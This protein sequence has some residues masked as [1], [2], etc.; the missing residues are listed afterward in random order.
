MTECVSNHRAVIYDRGGINKLWE[1][2]D[3]SRVIWDRRRDA[4]S[5]ATI[6]L[7]GATCLAQNDT[8]KQIR[9]S[10]HELVIFRGQ[11]RVWEGPITRAHGM[12]TEFSIFAKDVLH[13]TNRTA[14]HYG[15]DNRHPNTTTVLSRAELV[16]LTEMERKEAEEFAAFPD[17]P[18]YNII[19]HLVVHHGVGDARTAMRTFP[20]QYEVWE[21]IDSMAA[22]NGMDYT[23]IGRAIHFWD[24][25]NSLGQTPTVTESDFIGNLSV[26]EYGMELGTR[27][28]VTDGEGNYGEHGGVDPYYGLV[29][30]LDT[31]YDES[32]G[33]DPPTSSEMASQAS[34]NIAGRNPTPIQVRVPDNSSINP[35]GVLSLDMLVPGVWVPVRA[36]VLGFEIVQMQKLQSMRVTETPGKEDIQVTMYPAAIDDSEEEE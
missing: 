3:L 29:E 8:L 16:F 4:I 22:K 24:V 2:T 26:T 14:M 27:G 31:A 23:A 1:L 28:I 9:S 5:E 13:Y 18:S 11:D 32:E 25:H 10:R 33:A 15:Y 30:R 17:L 6:D 35:A 34:R 19:D 21:H 36:D 7:S 12:G 20:M